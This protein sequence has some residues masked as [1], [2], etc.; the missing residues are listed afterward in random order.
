MLFIDESLQKCAIELQK[1]KKVA[2][3]EHSGHK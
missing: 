1:Q 2:E 3:E